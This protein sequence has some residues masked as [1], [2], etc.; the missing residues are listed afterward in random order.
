MCFWNIFT[1]T[2]SVQ[3]FCESFLKTWFC[4]HTSIRKW[5]TYKVNFHSNIAIPLSHDEHKI[6]IIRATE[7]RTTITPQKKHSML[8]VIFNSQPWKTS[9]CSH[10]HYKAT[11]IILRIMVSIW[12]ITWMLVY[13]EIVTKWSYLHWQLGLPPNS[14]LIVSWLEE[15]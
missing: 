8:H 6:F 9:F 13:K 7:F 4:G 2:L 10:C 12:C 14:W 15:A 1:V 11:A 3:S 5:F